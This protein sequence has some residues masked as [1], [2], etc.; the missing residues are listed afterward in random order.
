MRLKLGRLVQEKVN[1]ILRNNMKLLELSL[2]SALKSFKDDP[3]TCRYLLQKSELTGS[4]QL[5]ASIPK[6]SILM[7]VN[8]NPVRYSYNRG[9]SITHKRRGQAIIVTPAMTLAIMQRGYPEYIT[10]I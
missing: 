5:I 6:S 10:K 8:N 2:I 9:L 1:M 7:S 3:N 4:S